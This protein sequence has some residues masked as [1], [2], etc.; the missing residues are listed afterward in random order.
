MKQ[1]QPFVHF[2]ASS[3]RMQDM[4]LP[5]F[6]TTPMQIR[7]GGGLAIYLILRAAARNPSIYLI[8]G[9][10]PPPPNLQRAVGRRSMTVEF[11]IP[12]S[13]PEMSGKALL[14]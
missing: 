7:W 11:I 5:D 9:T 13:G 10:T 6:Q 3:P 4:S 2:G 12:G 14:L 8:L 1:N